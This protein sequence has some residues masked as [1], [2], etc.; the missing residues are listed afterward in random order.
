MKRNAY[1]IQA[2]RIDI[3]CIGVPPVLLVGT[4]KG[5]FEYV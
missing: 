5:L 4:Q 3:P 2:R 1:L